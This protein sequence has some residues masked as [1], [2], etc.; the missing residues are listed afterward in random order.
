MILRVLQQRSFCRIGSARAEPA[1]VWVIAATSSDLSAAV[2]EHRFREDLYE[3]LRRL[4]LLIPPLRQRPEDI[5]L[6]A[7]HSLARVCVEHQLSANVF[8]P[9]A[10]SALLAYGWPGN[11]REVEHLVEHV[12]LLSAANDAITATM[13][14]SPALNEPPG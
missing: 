13:L 4:D 14:A 11:V 8:A 2:R 7:E 3:Y 1:D 5:L 12:A 9:D 6:L 10:R